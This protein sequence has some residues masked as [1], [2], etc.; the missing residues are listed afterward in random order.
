MEAASPEAQF[1][2]YDQAEGVLRAC[3]LSLPASASVWDSWLEKRD[4]EIRSRLIRG[5]EDSLV[6]FVLFGVSF[7]RQP[8]IAPANPDPRLI[9]ARVHDFIRA[10]LSARD[11]ERLLWLQDLIA[12]RG[13]TDPESLNRY[14]V[15]NIS[16]YLAEQQRYRRVLENAPANDPVSAQLYRDR[17]LS[18]DTNFRPNY[19]IE[20]ALVELKRRG[21]L[22]SVH[23][24]AIIGPGLDFTDKDGGF[25]YYPLQTLQ[26]FAVIDSLLRLGLAKLPELHVS[27]LDISSQVLDHLSRRQPPY[28][29]QLTLDRARPWNR[30]AVNYWRHLGDRVGIKVPALP[31]PPQIQHVERR[32]IR[33]RP[34]V[35]AALDPQPLNIVLQ[36]LDA[37][38]DLVIATN[39][40]VYYNALDQVLSGLNIESMLGTGGIFLSNTPLEECPGE[41]LHSIGNIQVRYSRGPGDDDRIEIYS[42][43]PLRRGLAPE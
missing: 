15:E 37:H 6:N 8:R 33:I 22:T 43:A 11:D 7:T 28:T 20:R 23:R 19:A 42:N 26:P 5:Q 18:V 38:Y 35:W 32:A 25:D 3:R 9:Q 1:P 24:V 21:T 31:A 41:S 39:V 30:E 16:R 36:H 29:I 34:D 14:V 13:Y 40:F 27:V 17:G 10:V 4:S 2:A 12:A